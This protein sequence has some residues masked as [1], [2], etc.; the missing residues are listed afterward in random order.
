V[1]KPLRIGVFGGTFDP[2][3]NVHL[4][5]ARAARD[6]AG[7]DRVLFVVAAT[8]PH[9]RNDVVASAEDRLAMVRAAIEGEHGFEACRI[10]MDRSGPSYTVDTVRTLAQAHPEARL[11]LII[12]YDTALDLPRWRE[13]Q[14][15][16]ERARLIVV[17]RPE[18]DSALDPS[19]DGVH[20]V[21]PFEASDLSSTEV[22]D[23]LAQGGDVRG[24]LPPAV[25]DYIRMKGLYACR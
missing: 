2:V 1:D 14:G 3:H 13:P 25:V 10:E 18:C 4:R 21:L 23:M 12:G 20:E 6:S 24:L 7:L 11:H 17:R 5:I 16:L 8:P 15:I 9:K 22:R 19:L